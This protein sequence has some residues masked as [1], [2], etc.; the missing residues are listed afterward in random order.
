MMEKNQHFLIPKFFAR[1]AP[2]S[3]RKEDLGPD[4]NPISA[5]SMDRL[6]HINN[7]ETGLTGTLGLDYEIKNKDK[8]FD[9][10][11]AQIINKR[12]NKKMS[13]E[14]SLDEKLSDLVGCG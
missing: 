3:M 4:L 13:S 8:S 9:F 2:G 10:S 12:E 6:D 5:F 1:Y 7:F 11:I 14:S